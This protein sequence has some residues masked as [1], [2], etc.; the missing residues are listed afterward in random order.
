M[1]AKSLLSSCA[2]N[3]ASLFFKIVGEMYPVYTIQD[4]K[5]VTTLQNKVE[6]SD[7]DLYDNVIKNFQ[8]PNGYI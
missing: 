6:I 8:L 3:L 5:G 7:T 2:S 1:G 4:D